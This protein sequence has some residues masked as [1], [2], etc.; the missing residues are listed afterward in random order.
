M[1]P[2]PSSDSNV[3]A[4]NPIIFCGAGPGDPDLITVKG[5]QALAAADLVV[6]AG[7]LV[8]EALLK[9]TRPGCRHLSSAG[10]HLDEMVASMADAHTDGK[11]VVRLHTG[12]P[13]LYGAIFE[14]MAKLS[15]RGIPYTVIPG[16]TAAFAAA[17]ALG[18]E[19]TLPEISQTL[20]L[21]RMAGRTPVPEAETLAALAA[22]QATM[23]IYLSIS[24]IDEMAR[25]LGDAY[26]TEA[27]CA[28]VYRA[29]QPD[30]KILW[31][32]IGRLAET[33]REAGIKRT[34]LVMVGRVL[35]VSLETLKHHSKLYDRHFAH[36]YRDAEK[37]Q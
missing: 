8:P 11:K 7:S 21:T 22:H 16:V 2:S 1:E 15:E 27:V 14:Q 32:P 5:Q 18:I 24:M 3:S 34:A 10:L 6:Y 33:V 26:G 19:Y 29:S 30:Q 23:A 37:R 4:P 25:T 35:D 12:D 36:G 17:A 9:W 13:S 20:I 31:T 28:V